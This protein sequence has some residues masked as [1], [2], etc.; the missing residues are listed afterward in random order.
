MVVMPRIFV[1]AT[2]GD[3]KSRC[4][5]VVAALRKL[6]TCTELL[7]PGDT[8]EQAQGKVDQILEPIRKK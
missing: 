1:S 7:N 4:A 8:E 3:L 6:E 2:S 5:T